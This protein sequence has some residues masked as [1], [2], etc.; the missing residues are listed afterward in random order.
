M[1]KSTRLKERSCATPCSEEGWLEWWSTEN[2][3]GKN[4]WLDCE[5]ISVNLY[6]KTQTLS[7]CAVHFEFKIL[8][9]INGEIMAD[10]RM[11]F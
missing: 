11:I 10:L 9:K 1:N 5:A 2:M 3:F 4:I 8:C 6:F 7:L